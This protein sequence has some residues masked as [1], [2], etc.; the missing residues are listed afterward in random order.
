MPDDEY[1][2]SDDTE[3]EIERL[4]RIGEFFF[5]KIVKFTFTITTK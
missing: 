4:S 1:F 5:D 3:Q 2:G